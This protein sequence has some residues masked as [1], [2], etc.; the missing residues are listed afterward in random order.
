MAG[1]Q[2][3][4]SWREAVALT[5]L[6]APHDFGVVNADTDSPV[7]HAH[8]WNN[9]A[10]SV[11][12]PNM[13]DCTIT[14]KDPTSGNTTDVVIGKWLSVCCLSAGDIDTNPA[15]WYAVGGTTDVELGTL[16]SGVMGYQ[17]PIKAGGLDTA[18]VGGV[19]V[20]GNVITGN[21]NSGVIGDLPNY[22]DLKMKA[23]VPMN[24]FAGSI[25]FLIRVDFK[26]T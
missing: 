8:L 16:G 5:V 12:V 7:L 3:I 14:T 24:A 26:Y 21:I 1:P 20:L 23:H 13:T 6:T 22:A 25:D 9:F 18:G 15:N 11:A 17:H 2:P 10:G 19:A 4:P